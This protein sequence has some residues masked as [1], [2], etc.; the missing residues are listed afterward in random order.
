[1]KD[2]NYYIEKG[3]EW[4][5][6][7]D[8]KELEEIRKD[9]YGW[10]NRENERNEKVQKREGFKSI[11]GVMN[12][13]QA[14]LWIL[15]ISGQI[16]DGIWENDPRLFRGEWKYYSW[17]IVKLDGSGFQTTAYGVPKI[18][19]TRMLREGDELIG[20]MIIKVRLTVNPNYT[21]ENLV[22]D[23]RSLANMIKNMKEI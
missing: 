14:V 7:D 4:M 19:V 12:K 16:S 21:Y 18:G 13:E 10:L 9:F 23:I 1:M 15:E 17:A 11:L 5:F 8:Y 3:K 2:T 22:R 6:E 20:R